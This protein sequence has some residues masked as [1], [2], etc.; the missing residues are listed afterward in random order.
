M[1]TRQV[2][3][4]ILSQ[5]IF[6]LVKTLPTNIQLTFGKL[7]LLSPIFGKLCLL[8]FIKDNKL[9]RLIVGC[10]VSLLLF[11]FSGI[12]VAFELWNCVIQTKDHI[13]TIIPLM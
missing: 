1:E 7:C 5:R 9:A 6:H 8:F 13:R 4:H 12:S 2:L 10:F 3:T 11:F